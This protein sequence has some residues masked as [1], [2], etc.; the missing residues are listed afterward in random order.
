VNAVAAPAGLAELAARATPAAGLKLA[1]VYDALAEP[2]CGE[3]LLAA[4]HRLDPAAPV[5]APIYRPER[6]S[7]AFR[8][9]DVRTS[10]LQHHASL[11]EHHRRYLARCADAMARFDLSGF[12]AVLSVSR[13]FAKG[14]RVPRGTLHVCYCSTPM[15]LAWDRPAFLLEHGI[16]GA[17]RTRLVPGSG[18]LR[19]WDVQ[20]AAGV[21]HF[22]APS[23][24]VA[25][26]IAAAFRR[27]ATVLPPPVDAARFYVSAP[28]DYLLVVARLD[29]RANV[30]LAIEAAKRA[31]RRLLV[32]G[33]GP[34][35]AALRQIAGPGV[36]FLGRVPDA[37][38]P[39]LMACA[40]ALIVPAAAEAEV[41][42]L[43]AMASGRPVIA[44]GEGLA[45]DVVVEGETGVLFGAPTPDSLVLALQRFESMRVDEQAIRRYALR[46]D[47]ARFLDRL[48]ALL[49][50]RLAAFRDDPLWSS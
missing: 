15:R 9:I 36:R 46:F 48:T 6:L 29:A 28:D 10:F 21:H 38:L 3:H 41:A 25:A 7:E 40:R 18:R 22:V 47:T 26:R 44:L 17:L 13:A 34:A 23:R 32:A 2:E 50:D 31:G 43:E 35:E 45:A 14:V 1:L 16:T 12:D 20:T 4:L 27:D 39:E 11:A 49:R 19:A 8:A 33:A 24:A 30:Q 5:F 37:A 42:M